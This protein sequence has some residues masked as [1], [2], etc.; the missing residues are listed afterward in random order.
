M[1]HTSCIACGNDTTEIVYRLR[2]RLIRADDARIFLLCRCAQCGLVYLNPQPEWSDL[3]YFYGSDYY[4]NIDGGS[5]RPNIAYRVLRKLKRAVMGPLRPQ[6][7]HF[8]K[9]EGRFLDIGCGNAAYEGYV[10]SDYPGWEFYAVEPSHASAVLAK[11]VPHLNVFEGLLE[12]A[13]Y[14]ADFFDVI[15]M[16]HSLEHTFDPCA[17]LREVRRILRPGGRVVI[18][19]PNFMSPSRRIFGEYWYH[20]DA[21]RHLF[22][23]MPVVLSAMLRNVGFEIDSVRFEALSGSVLR[24]I[25]YR[26]GIKHFFFERPLVLLCI[27]Y[28]FWPFKKIIEFLGWGSG[29]EIIARKART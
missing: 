25:A 6:F 15:L 26:Y 7:F 18:K 12:D 3:E 4:T 19:V 14:P 21:P 9:R 28:L 23:F 10:M 13:Q 22:H 17:A 20:L 5:R 24:S 1:R 11:R 16:S 8:E 27:H 2:D 29:Q